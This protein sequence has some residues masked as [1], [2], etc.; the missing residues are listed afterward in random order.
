M[1]FA[2][3]KS[4]SRLNHEEFKSRLYE[5]VSEKITGIAIRNYGFNNWVLDLGAG[6]VLDKK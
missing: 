1:F 5:L 4:R 6:N 2:F 3:P